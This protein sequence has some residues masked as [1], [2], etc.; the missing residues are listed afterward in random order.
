MKSPVSLKMAEPL[1]LG[2]R[3]SRLALTQSRQVGAAIT[4]VTG[5]AVELVQFTTRGDRIQDKP[6]PEIGGKGL[7]TAELECALR[8]GQIDLAVDSLKDLPTDDPDGL[9]LGAIPKRVDARDALVGSALAS[10]PSGSV[11]ATG[12]VRRRVQLLDLRP[13]LVVQ[14]IRGNVPTR[15]Q[16]RD[17]GQCAATILAM[18]GLQRLGIERSD[19]HPFGVETMIPAVGQGALGVQCRMDDPRVLRLLAGV[20]DEQTRRCV[21]AERAFLVAV[22][23]G[24]NVPAGCHAVIDGDSI[25]AIACLHTEERGLRRASARSSEPAGLGRAL[26]GALLG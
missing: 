12:S 26:A 15:I 22:G 23:G 14:D 3:G 8:E 4:A 9:M 18:A 19:I 20:D 2:T 10:L 16:K 11:V 21:D 7:F 24:C 17:D 25:S 5:V 6:L 13:D 1:R